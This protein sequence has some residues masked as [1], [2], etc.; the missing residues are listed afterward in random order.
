MKDRSYFWPLVLIAIGMLWLLVNLGTLPT[1]NLWALVHMVPFA[2]IALGFG[3]ILRAFW[4]PA[5]MIVSVLVVVGAVLGVVYAEQ[6]GWNKFPGWTVWTINSPDLGG[7]VAGSGVQRSESRDVSDFTALSIEY[8]VDITIQQGE[9][10]ALTI[11]TDDNL[12][13]QIST[14]V[15]GST[16]VIENKIRE[17]NQRVRPS[18][19]VQITLTVNDISRVDFTSAGKLVVESYQGQDLQV[20]LS[21]AGEVQLHETEL[22]TL[23]LILSGAGDLS[24]DGSVK[25]LSLRISGFGSFDGA[26]LFVQN[27]DVSISGAGD[28]MLRVEQALDV[29][30]SGAG[31]VR[32]YGQP[33]SVSKQISGAGN[34]SQIGE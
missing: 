12:L 13:P 9:S 6:L 20:T 34:V 24:A 32:Y 27:A 1:A 22:D 19:T 33:E 11:T 26:D 21:G 2:L 14:E 8:P 23:N 7:R 30:I 28:A 31:S 16:L 5:G 17:W 29:R 18:E 15:Q 3:L 25:D 4:R 10:P